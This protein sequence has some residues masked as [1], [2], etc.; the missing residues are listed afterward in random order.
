ML[1]IVMIVY[2]FKFFVKYLTFIYKYI[3]FFI[4]INNI[5]FYGDRSVIFFFNLI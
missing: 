3:L 4:I 1:K 5:V 2:F